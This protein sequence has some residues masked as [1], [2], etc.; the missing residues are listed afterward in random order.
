MIVVRFKVQCEPGS[1]SD[2]LAV[3]TAVVEPSRGLPGVIHFDIARD[4]IDP[5]ALIA[6]EVFED[7]D[8][9]E[10]QESQPEVAEVVG[11]MES[12]ALVAPPEW[13]IYDVA[14]AESPQM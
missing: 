9:M 1:T 6:V 12:G 11:L 2:V 7:R 3:M 10:R 8:A 5:N 13:T 4:V 14:S